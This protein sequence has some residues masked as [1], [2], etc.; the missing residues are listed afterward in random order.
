[1]DL[2]D[3]SRALNIKGEVFKQGIQ[4]GFLAEG[5]NTFLKV[6][7]TIDNLHKQKKYSA[8]SNI[9][10]TIFDIDKF[11]ILNYYLFTVFR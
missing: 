9:F 4:K 11:F 3:F 8:N 5:S 6:C 2:P 1:M 7:K 10:F